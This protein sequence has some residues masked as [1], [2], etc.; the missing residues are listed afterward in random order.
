MDFFLHPRASR[1]FWI[2]I[3]SNQKVVTN[4]VLYLEIYIFQ[5]S[6]SSPYF[7]CECKGPEM[8][9]RGGLNQSLKFLS[10]YFAAILISPPNTQSKHH[11]VPDPK[12]GWMFH[13]NTAGHHE[14]KSDY[15]PQRRRENELLDVYEEEAKVPKSKIPQ[16]TN[17][18]S[19]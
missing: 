16:P 7:I 9:T 11:D 3:I 18:K 10:K 5:I 1:I 4:K 15:F 14:A 6:L 12:S 13:R 8:V 2:Q 17:D 19:T